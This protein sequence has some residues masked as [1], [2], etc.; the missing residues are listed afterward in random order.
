MG[1]PQSLHK[2][3][4][5]HGDPV[6]GIDPSG[7]LVVFGVAMSALLVVSIFILATLVIGT[8]IH[9][10]VGGKSPHLGVMLILLN[11]RLFGLGSIIPLASTIVHETTHKMNWQRIPF[12]FWEPTDYQKQ[13]EYFKNKKCTGNEGDIHNNFGIPLPF[14]KDQVDK[15]QE[16]N[17]ENPAWSR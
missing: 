5:C 17:I 15:Y 2:Y 14:I 1:D 16:Y 13:S 4:Y 6:M 12:F 8:F 10:N 11:S 9:D 7:S 3:A